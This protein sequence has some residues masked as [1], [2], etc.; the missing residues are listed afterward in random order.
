MNRKILSVLLSIVLCL[1][2]AVA[3]SAASNPALLTAA[4]AETL[5][6]DDADLLSTAEE[7]ELSENL[8]NISQTYNAQIIVATV[9]SVESGDVDGYVEYLYD[10][11]GFGYGSDRDGVLLLVCMNP[12]EYRI[13]SN[14]FAGRAIAGSEID[15]I[16]E[17]IVSDLS[18][19]YYANAFDGFARKCAYYLDGHLNGFP[20]NFSKNLTTALIIGLVAG[21]IVA[22][23][24]KA[25]LKSVHKQN[26]ANVYVK[27][28]SMQVTTS[29]DLF[30]YRNVSRTKKSSNSSSSGSS[31]SVGGGS[32]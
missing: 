4:A 15:A 14:G 9:A 22:L 30:L 32:F 29:R 24:L 27:S 18:D 16:G 23:A 13:L 25:Q 12:R 5:V 26:Q 28:G 11:M 31:R 8:H 21:L 17:A 19:G 3:A 2:F 1:S 7:T 20:F 10:S 6:F